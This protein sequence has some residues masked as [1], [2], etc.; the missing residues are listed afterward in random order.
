MELGTYLVI[1]WR[2]KG[3]I[4]VTFVLTL[5]VAAAGTMMMTPIYEAS[6]TLCISA[7]SRSIDYGDLLYMTRLM[8]SFPSIVG[9]GPILAELN[10]QIGTDA[11]PELEVVFPAESDLMQI[12]VKDKDP[13]LAARAANILAELFASS[14]R[15][16]KTGRYFDVTLVDPAVPPKEPSSPRAALNVAVGALVGLAGGLGLAFLFENLDTTLYTIEEVEACAEA[17]VLGQIPQGV[18]EFS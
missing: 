4:V 15:S 17:R 8:N 6:A 11:A 9:S 10:R 2:R 14:L 13:A 12:V 18:P 1:L 3:I 16:T 7:D 5:A